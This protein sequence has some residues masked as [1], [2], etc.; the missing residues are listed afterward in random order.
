[1]PRLVSRKR[2][3]ECEAEGDPKK[4][5]SYEVAIS[6]KPKNEYVRNCLG[7]NVDNNYWH[8]V[9]HYKQKPLNQAGQV[10]IQTLKNSVMICS[11]NQQEF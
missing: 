4:Q 8:S 11:G 5:T 7:G 9:L 1:V 2:Y 10:Q 6:V 3:S